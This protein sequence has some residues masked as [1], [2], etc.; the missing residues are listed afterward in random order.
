MI[1]FH[2]VIPE[3]ELNAQKVEIDDDVD[4]VNEN[5]RSSIEDESNDDDEDDDACEDDTTEDC[6]SDNF[7]GSDLAYVVLCEIFVNELK[8][9]SICKRIHAYK[10]DSVRSESGEV[11]EN[12]SAGWDIGM[13]PFVDDYHNYSTCVFKMK[14]LFEEGGRYSG[15]L[16]GWDPDWLKTYSNVYKRFCE[17]ILLIVSD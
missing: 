14:C 1:F 7:E 15:D 17:A 8:Y 5:E 2:E 12:N 11:E 3:A 10:K 6:A 9:K 13:H 4:K 16:D